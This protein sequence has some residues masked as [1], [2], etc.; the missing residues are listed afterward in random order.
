MLRMW[1][2]ILRLAGKRLT[3]MKRMNILRLT[4]KRLALMK[5]MA[6]GST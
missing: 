2:N 1:V 4:G 3:L 5:R 6:G